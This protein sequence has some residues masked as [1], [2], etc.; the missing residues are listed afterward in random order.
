V[1]AKVCSAH[2]LR[3]LR[4]CGSGKSAIDGRRRKKNAHLARI[5]VKS[6]N[7]ILN[8]REILRIIIDRQ[9]WK[10]LH[11]NKSRVDINN[12]LFTLFI[13]QKI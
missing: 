9:S 11:K 6:Y 4:L 2:I 7:V 13:K 1:A 12:K 5:R 10:V 8:K 3:A